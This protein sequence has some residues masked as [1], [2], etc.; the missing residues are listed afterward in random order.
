MTSAELTAHAQEL[1]MNI[2]LLFG[3]MTIIGS[4]AHIRIATQQTPT[5]T[6]YSLR[7]FMLTFGTYGV[8]SIPVMK[9][10]E[11][12]VTTPQEYAALYLTALCI[13]GVYIFISGVKLLP[14][15]NTDRGTGPRPTTLD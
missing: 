1:Y 7:F 10:L 13:G 15:T 5:A 8:V 14:Q 12:Y 4:L 9:T 6:S 11:S 2:W 3:L